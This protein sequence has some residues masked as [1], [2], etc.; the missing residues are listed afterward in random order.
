MGEER[1]DGEG[2][3]SAIAS[4]LRTVRT[5][6]TGT[7]AVAIARGGCVCEGRPACGANTCCCC[8]CCCCSW[9]PLLLL[10]L[11]LL[12][13]W[14]LLLLLLRCCCCC[15]PASEFSGRRVRSIRSPE[16]RR[17]LLVVGAT[18]LVGRAVC[19]EALR[20]GHD[21]IAMS[22]S[23]ASLCAAAAGDRLSA[24]RRCPDR[25]RCELEALRADALR[26]E[27]YVNARA[28]AVVHTPGQLLEADYKGLL[29]GGASS[30][31]GGASV[32]MRAGWRCFVTLRVRRWPVPASTSVRRLLPARAC[33]CVAVFM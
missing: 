13:G 10:L 2:A 30:G 27:T 8:C 22:R 24:K 21:V 32:A 15:R 25:R 20:R 19:G 6:Y 33:A 1:A 9:P 31:S 4:T 17:T 14:P 18:G 29:G 12:L 3:S 26:A 7:E 5:R 11:L 16:S 28:D 23:G